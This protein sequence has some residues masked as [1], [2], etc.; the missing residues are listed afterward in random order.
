MD[1]AARLEARTTLRDRLQALLETREGDLADLL[2]VE[3]ELANVQAELDAQASVLAALRQRVDTSTL[4]LSYTAARSPLQPDAYDPIGQAL[5]EVGDVF[6]DSVADILIF[7]AGLLPWLVIGGPVL[8]LLA[9]IARRA[10]KRRKP[11]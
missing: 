3:R 4:S 1:A 7:L 9:W 5:S 10:L 11:A 8:A 2:A 6:A